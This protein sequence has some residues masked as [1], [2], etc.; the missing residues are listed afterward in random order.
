MNAQPT[1]NKT[2]ARALVIFSL[3][4]SF[5][6]YKYLIEVSPSIMTH[7]L[8]AFF[9]INAVHL[10]NI[11]ASYYYIYFI[12]Q[13]PMGI[14]LDRLGPRKVMTTCII[15]CALGTLIFAYSQTFI[16]A[17]GG[18]FLTGL[19]ASVAAI[20]TLKLITLWF[21]RKYFAL[22]TGLM[23]TIGMLGAVF[24][25]AP[26]SLAVDHFNW[27]NT[28]LF[29]SLIGF[30]LTIIFGLVVS[31]K[32]PF[33]TQPSKV[34]TP[35]LWQGLKCVLSKPQTW[36]LSLYSGFAF[37]PITAFGGLWGVPFLEKNY[38]LSHTQAAFSASLIFIGFAI[39]AP[40]FG[41]LSERHSKRKPLMTLGTI[42]AF[43]ILS[44]IIFG[45]IH[46]LV[47]MQFLLLSFGT[48]LAGFLLCFSMVR[49]V[50]PLI[51]A[52]TVLGFMNAFDA[53]MS[54]ITDPL[55]GY[56]LDY[57]K[58]API[59]TFSTYDFTAGITTLLVYLGIAVVLLIKLKE[60]HCQQ[61]V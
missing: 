5:L 44:I 26:L 58:K 38:V 52:G 8:M 16:I 11:A 14:L 55:I 53:A 41:F 12:M 54:A 20:G 60:T 25:E 56:I 36:W 45:H 3:A 10:G 50:N 13:L 61:Q 4:V 33:A 31:D 35:S 7:R 22:M 43:I 42:I 18:R 34:H 6:F 27:H 24:G 46:S 48:S 28:L 51:L 19:G 40:L 2:S 39:G 37:A 17:C 15:L 47:L 23:M 30:L 57:G 1:T 59:E 9:K 29:L 49:E 32:A 21:N